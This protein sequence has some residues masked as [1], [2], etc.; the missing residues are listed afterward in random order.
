MAAS[1]VVGSLADW[2]TYL[3]AAKRH[4]TQ[5]LSQEEA[6]LWVGEDPTRRAGVRNGE[7][8]V[9]PKMNKAISSH[10]F[11]TNF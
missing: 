10:V 1:L 6:F 4:M 11:E 7:I 9:S 5:H 3:D 8:V 2:Q